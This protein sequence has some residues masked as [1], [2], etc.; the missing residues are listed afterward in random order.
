MASCVGSPARVLHVRER[1]DGVV[2]RRLVLVEVLDEGLDPAL[3]LEDVL[4]LA[5]RSRSST[6]SIVT[7]RVQ[8]REL[9]QALRERVEVVARDGEDLRVG[10][11]R[12][13]RARLRGLADLADRLERDALAVALLPDLALALDLDEERARER[14][15]DGQA[16]AVEAARDLVRVVVELAARVEVREDDL[17]RLALVDG[18]RPD[19]DAAAV[20]LDGDGVVRVD[21]RR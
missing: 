8:E 7:P 5:L 4:L 20:V 21:D 9:A 10:L 3:V 15:H 6:T 17:E 11:E 2:E 14:V 16:D 1:D 12:D 13:L 19:R 18:V